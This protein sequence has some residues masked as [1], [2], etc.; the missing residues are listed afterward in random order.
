MLILGCLVAQLRYYGAPGFGQEKCQ[1]AARLHDKSCVNFRQTGVGADT[2][3]R[4][5]YWRK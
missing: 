3:S 4:L 2:V 5:A 1:S